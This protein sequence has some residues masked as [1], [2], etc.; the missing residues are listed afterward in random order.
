MGFSNELFCEA[1]SFSCCLNLHKVFQ[2]E[3]LR[4]YFPSLEPWVAQS[5]LLPNCSS[6]FIHTE[7][8]DC[9]VCKMLMC[10]VYQCLPGPPYP[11]SCHLSINPLCP[12]CLSPPLLPVWVNVSSLTPWLLDFHIVRFFV[13]SGCFLFLNCCCPSFGCARRYTSIYMYV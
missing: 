2:S 10:L 5:C 3:V 12:G 9:P 6:W 1:G 7:M 11:S 4:F 8:W 13:S